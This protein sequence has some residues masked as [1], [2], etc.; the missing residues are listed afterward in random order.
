VLRD[1]R[2]G[3]LENTSHYYTSDSFDSFQPTLIY[4]NVLSVNRKYKI[5]QLFST[6]GNY[7]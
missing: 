6:N 5:V 7:N 2:D 1:V 4:K 3:S